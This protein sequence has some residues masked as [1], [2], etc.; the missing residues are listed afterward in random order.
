MA[1]TESHLTQLPIASARS[2]T[3]I[4]ADILSEVRL[5]PDGLRKTRLMYRCNLSYRQLKIYLKLLVNK[6]FLSVAIAK[7]GNMKVE[8]YKITEEG[9]SFLEAYNALRD[10][11]GER[12]ATR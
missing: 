7:V 4:M 9:L 3:D 11:L 12:R 5:A 6:R 2:R 1:R 8:I 10:R